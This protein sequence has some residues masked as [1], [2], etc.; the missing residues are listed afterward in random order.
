[1]L[2]ALTGGICTG[3]PISIFSLPEPEGREAKGALPPVGEQG[4]VCR[5]PSGDGRLRLGVFNAPRC[6]SFPRSRSRDFN[7]ACLA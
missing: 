2:M 3:T 1:M 7:S 6:A 4:T 5:L